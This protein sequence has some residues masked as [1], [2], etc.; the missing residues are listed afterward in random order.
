MPLF[1]GVYALYAFPSTDL[2]NVGTSTVAPG[3]KKRSVT[4][5]FD[6]EFLVSLLQSLKITTKNVSFNRLFQIPQK[7]RPWMPLLLHLIPPQRWLILDT[8]L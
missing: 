2:P 3:R 7:Y 5:A 1:G 6:T 4:A 8:L